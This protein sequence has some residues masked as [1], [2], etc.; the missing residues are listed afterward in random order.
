MVRRVGSAS[1]GQ[2]FHALVTLAVF[3]TLIGAP[4]A[5]LSVALL[6]RVVL[7]VD[8]GVPVRPA[9][10]SVAGLTEVVG[11]VD[12]AALPTGTGLA[13]LGL[14]LAGVLATVPALEVLRR[15][16]GAVLRG[17]PFRWANLR[18]LTWLGAAVIGAAAAS[19][20]TTGAASWLAARATGHESFVPPFPGWWVLGPAVL[21]LTE[22]FRVGARL[23][24]DDDLTV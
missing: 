24:H 11:R 2:V 7:G 21:G 5:A 19:W 8:V 9:G 4:L 14:W 10:G 17:E 3:G 23:Q 1:W 20:L 6:D 22:V 16:T 15:I 18:L 12:P 13:V